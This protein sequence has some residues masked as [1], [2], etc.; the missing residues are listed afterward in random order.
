MHANT[1]PQAV[2]PSPCAHFI[3]TLA[4]TAITIT[5]SV[6]S[7]CGE[8]V[9][10]GLNARW[11]LET[12]ITMPGFS[13]RLTSDRQLEPG[14]EITLTATGVDIPA[15]EV[16]FWVENYQRTPI[17]EMQILDGGRLIRKI[18]D[19]EIPTNGDVT[20]YVALPIMETGTFNIALGDMEGPRTPSIPITVGTPERRMTQAEAADLV[21]DGIALWGQTMQAVVD[22]PDEGWTAFKTEILGS[23]GLAGTDLIFNEVAE[24]AENARTEYNALDPEIE[25]QLQALLWNLGLLPMFEEMRNNAATDDMTNTTSL[26]SFTFMDNGLPNLIERRVIH[27]A[28][29]KID[30]IGARLLA[31]GAFADMAN[32]VATAF[33]GEALPITLSMTVAI[34]SLRIIA[35][36]MLPTET[37]KLELHP[38]FVL[39]SHPQFRTRD[40]DNRWIYWARMEP[41]TSIQVAA[42][43]LLGV[44]VSATIGQAFPLE[45]IFQETINTRITLALGVLRQLVQRLG[46]DV[47][48]FFDDTGDR[49]ITIMTVADTSLFTHPLDSTDAVIFIPVIGEAIEEIGDFFLSFVTEPAMTITSPAFPDEDVRGWREL[50]EEHLAV[51]HP[52]ISGR[53]SDMIE[54]A[55]EPF[56]FGTKNIGFATVPVPVSGERNVGTV[57][58]MNWNEY[59]RLDIPPRRVWHYDRLN[60]DSQIDAQTGSWITANT[61]TERRHIVEASRFDFAFLN[62]VS[63][64]NQGFMLQMSI[65]GSTPI[66]LNWFGEPNNDDFV[67]TVVTL[68]P[69]LNSIEF[70]ATHADPNLAGEPITL[71]LRFPSVID[72]Q[73]SGGREAEKDL[74]WEVGP[75]ADPSITV[76]FWTPPAFEEE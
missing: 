76:Q 74:V 7:G 44:G 53:E 43:R 45:K 34:N 72:A 18:V 61:D 14:Q 4:L 21:A 1:S 15:D 10:S 62:G 30:V 48:S 52:A 26:A 13:G 11:G 67:S 35:D 70:S 41:Q 36:A 40:L 22:D 51:R 28:L 29:F 49:A 54:V 71:H 60:H 24:I 57:T 59:D 47:V 5:A 32:I 64:E 46:F 50:T 6:L 17:F 2:C 12:F 73:T 69:G 66:G 42:G 9:I 38:Q 19:S 75:G 8:V 27:L 31:A 37:T 55:L 58:A 63:A 16:M 25:Q 39:R 23:D 65:N 3:R 68:Q 56:S 33:G 20:Y